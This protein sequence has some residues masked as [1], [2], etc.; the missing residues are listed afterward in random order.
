MRCF[1]KIPSKVI[2]DTNTLFACSLIETSGKLGCQMKHDFYEHSNKLIEYIK[3]NPDKRIGVYTAFIEDEAYKVL[4]SAVETE[5]KKNIEDPKKDFEIFSAVLN[6]CNDNLRYILL[7]LIRE[8][9]NINTVDRINND[10]D[11]V[12]EDLLEEAKEAQ[13]K[14]QEQKVMRTMTL[15]MRAPFKRL[16]RQIYAQQDQWINAQLFNLL[17][18]MIEPSDKR[19]LSEVIYLHRMYKNTFGQSI[20]TYLASTDYH[21]SP[22]IKDGKTSSIVSDRINREFEVECNWPNIICDKIKK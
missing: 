13:E 19:I 15:P 10:V 22:I 6:M 1:K 8:P 18:K 14:L 12:Y 21:F 5:L 11:S 2:L 17:Y 20:K 16:A 4:S 3:K 7:Y 9:I